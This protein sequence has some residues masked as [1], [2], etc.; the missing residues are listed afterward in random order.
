MFRAS[1]IQPNTMTLR[2]AII[3]KH[4]LQINISIYFDTFIISDFSSRIMRWQILRQ[5]PYNFGNLIL[6]IFFTF[7]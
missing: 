5:K 1:V 3:T 6:N 4:S 2:A 7:M